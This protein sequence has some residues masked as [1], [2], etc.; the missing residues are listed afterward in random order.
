[1]NVI[2]PI[3]MQRSYIDPVLYN[4][5]QG[6]VY[7]DGTAY[8]LLTWS[9]GVTYAKDEYVTKD[10]CGAKVWQALTNNTDKDP[11]TSPTDWLEM[12]NLV[13]NCYAMFDQKINTRTIATSEDGTISIVIQPGRAVSGIGYANIRNV[14]SVYA[15]VED[16]VFGLMHESTTQ[17]VFKNSQGYFDWY[18]RGF[19]KQTN[20][21]LLDFPE[22]LT[23]TVTITFMPAGDAKAEVGELLIGEDVF[24]GETLEGVTLRLKDFSVYQ[25]DEFGNTTIIRRATRDMLEAD[26][27]ISNGDF[28]RIYR[29]LEENRTVPLYW[30]PSKT[31]YSGLRVIGFYSDL[32]MTV[33]ATLTRARLSVQ[34]VTKE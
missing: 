5:N 28:E 3:K 9:A 27:L 21:L 13:A 30:I 8:P 2:V 29:K 16:P 25:E 11:A 26:V 10:D 31:K 14:D 23:P 24:A 18:Y 7:V 6:E 17:M 1:M 19:S 33:D 32:N 4:V 12:K 34:G 22:S 15:K 20:G